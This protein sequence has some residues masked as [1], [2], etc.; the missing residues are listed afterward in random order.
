MV[1]E[2]EKAL[3]DEAYDGGF[4]YMGAE[5]FTAYVRTL[6]VT[7]AKV[8]E[9]AHTP[10]DDEREAQGWREA[11]LYADD[12]ESQDDFITGWRTADRLRR[13]EVPEPSAEGRISRA[14]TVL[15]WRPD[16]DGDDPARVQDDY[17]RRAQAADA[18]LAILTDKREGAF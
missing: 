7:A 16:H 3:R 10:I 4:G 17:M 1:D 8:V 6:A 13:T 2:I 11:A 15:S 9:E 18:A 5:Q 14:I 12:A